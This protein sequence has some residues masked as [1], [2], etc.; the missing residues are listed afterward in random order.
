MG[1]V[2][3]KYITVVTHS[4]FGYIL[5]SGLDYFA[6]AIKADEICLPAWDQKY[7]KN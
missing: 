4:V 3:S 7:K 2:H 6:L 5:L 1:Q